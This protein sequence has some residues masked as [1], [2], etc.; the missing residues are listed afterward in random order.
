MKAETSFSLKDQLFNPE[1]V[2]WLSGLF[3]GAY[4]GF[5]ENAFQT[6]VLE[7]FP[8]LELKERIV[9]ITEMLHKHLPRD[10]PEALKIVL[11][12]L[13]PEL[14]P[15]LK[16]D[17]FGDFMIA[18]LSHFV[19]TYGQA[20]EHLQLSLNALRELTKRFSAEDAIR[21]FINAYPAETLSF[22]TEGAK[23][24]NY[25]VRRLS[26]EGTRPKL[27]WCQKLII[28]HEQPLAILDILYADSTRFV[29]R[30][31]ANHLNDI[32][33]IAPATVVETLARW[34]ESKKQ[35]EKE[36]DFI[37]NHSLRTL[38]KKGDPEALNMIGFG[39]KPDVDIV[40]FS[41]ATPEVVV[42]NACEFVLKLKARKE[43]G[44]LID[45]IMDFASNGKKAGRKIFK[46]K[47]VKAQKGQDIVIKKK[48]P[49]KLMT[50]RRL[51][52]GEH[53]ITIQINGKALGSQTF[54]LLEP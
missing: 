7:K 9:H 24:K 45:Y 50:T 6:A 10:Y 44:L 1:K 28:D 26:S 18:P 30:S 15:S 23:H 37:I 31:V 52:A 12:A 40:E 43:Q 4:E 33:K 53:K 36:M 51:Y 39:G 29:T 27:P 16:D 20:P 2:A 49:L 48:H 19:A 14:D 17:D 8:D 32:S 47:Q 54:E 42:G 41:I 11:D 25:H 21:Y 3:S 35:S 38:I 13:P 34:K 5:D 46:L 22:L